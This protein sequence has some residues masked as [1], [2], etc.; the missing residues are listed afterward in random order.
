MWKPAFESLHDYFHKRLRPALGSLLETA[1]TAGQDRE[2]VEAVELLGAIAGM[3]IQPH[4]DGPQQVRRM[5]ALLV[6][7][8]RFR[9][10]VDTAP[11]FPRRL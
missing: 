7:R 6:D 9:A 4:D 11:A 3:C 8:L 10:R 5:V 1:A 2:D